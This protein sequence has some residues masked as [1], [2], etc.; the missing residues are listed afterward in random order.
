MAKD[1][2]AAAGGKK[3]PLPLIIGAVVLVLA[4]LVGPKVLGGSKAEPEK[5]KKK[6]QKAEVGHSIPLDEFLVNLNG[7]GDHYLKTTIALGV[8]KEFTEEKMK[9][10]TPAIRDT[11]LTILSS[12]SIKELSI[13]KKRE[14]LK[15][16]IMER[17]NEAMDDEVVVKVY[18]TAFATQ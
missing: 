16:E 2:E 11:I 10:H 13:P 15:K 12:K 4:I 9:E 14:E 18:F 7:S 17:I 1:K 3:K 5:A 8:P 6:K